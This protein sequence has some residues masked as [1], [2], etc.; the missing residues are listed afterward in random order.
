MKEKKQRKIK[1]KK[2]ENKPR[3]DWAG[4]ENRVD[5]LNK[6]RKKISMSDDGNTR[7]GVM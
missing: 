2:N 7:L 3:G 6:E 5:I 1:T 4:A